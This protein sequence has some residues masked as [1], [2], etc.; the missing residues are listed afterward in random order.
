MQGKLITVIVVCLFRAAFGTTTKDTRP[1]FTDFPV[2]EVY[3]GKPAPAQ[4]ASRFDHLF[5]T[6][7]RKGAEDGPNFAGHYT[8][9]VWGCGTS[10][11]QFVIVDASTGTVYD[12]PFQSVVG[13]DSK[14]LRKD[15][16]LHFQ[17][18]SALFVAQGCLNEK[19]CATRY[20][21]WDGER[22]V[23]L[24]AGPVERFPDPPCVQPA[25]TVKP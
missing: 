3:Q 21:Q 20:Y 8:V 24:G 19:N 4:L 12:P 6:V 1:L 9:V 15:W 7:I 10:C 5:R 2:Q 14:G 13:G 18:H 23:L 25:I 16:G 17:L 11:A 22:L